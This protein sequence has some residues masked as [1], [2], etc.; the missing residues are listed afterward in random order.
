HK[1]GL[2]HGDVSPKN[3]VH[4]KGE[5]YLTDY[6]L[7]LGIGE[8]VWS[9]GTPSYCSPSVTEGAPAGASNDVFSLAA[10][11]FHI[12]FDREP[13]RCGGQFAPERGLCWEGIARSEWGVVADFLDK[14]TSADESQWFPNAIVAAAY[15][16]ANSEKTTTGDQSSRLPPSP[17]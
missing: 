5:V 2:V 1:L 4:S 15:L 12:L 13:F 10:T 7:A 3:I 8:A 9:Q 14:A 16:E 6:D 11:L 17:S